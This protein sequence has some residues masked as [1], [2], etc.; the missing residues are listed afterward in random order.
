[1]RQP[2]WK[3]TLYMILNICSGKQ[4]LLFPLNMLVLNVCFGMPYRKKVV[5]NKS[6]EYSSMS[7]LRAI[8]LWEVSNLFED[9]YFH[10]CLG[11][12]VVFISFELCHQ[13]ICFVHSMRIMCTSKWWM[14]FTEFIRSYHLDSSDI[15]SIFRCKLQYWHIRGYFHTPMK[16]QNW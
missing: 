2:Q 12:Q 3:R 6:H 15:L 8:K 5:I 4:S 11:K 1:M 13:V 10:V 9:V 16:R 7:M 14:T